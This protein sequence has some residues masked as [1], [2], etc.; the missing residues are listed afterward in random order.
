MP[1]LWLRLIG[2]ATSQFVGLSITF[3]AK[4]EDEHEI[5]TPEIV[6]F[7]K[8]M[9]RRLNGSCNSIFDAV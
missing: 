3:T 9:I 4:I 6:S 8:A 2:T 5:S 1:G 7:K